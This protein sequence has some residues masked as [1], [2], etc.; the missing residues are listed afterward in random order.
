MILT[1]FNFFYLLDSDFKISNLARK[2]KILLILNFFTIFFIAKAA[3]TIGISLLI[4]LLF[5]SKNFNFFQKQNVVMLLSFSF[6]FIFIINFFEVDESTNRGL[7]YLVIIDNLE[8]LNNLFVNDWS[9]N[10]RVE[11]IVSPLIA[12]YLNNGFPGGFN[13]FID[14][15][16]EI[17]RV[18]YNL[19]NLEFV[20]KIDINNINE[21]KISSFIGDFIFQ[22]GIFGFII[23]LLLILKII[24][25]N[26][27]L[28]SLIILFIFF[29]VTIN[30]QMTYS[31]LPLLLYLAMYKKKFI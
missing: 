17:G 30:P 20:S 15:R 2:E 18:F 7:R 11:N 31:F 4:M 13:G 24:K 14:N 27:F 8:E 16:E 10:S 12:S 5:F 3:T 23:I 1:L 22:E 21:M 29:I 19:S 26:S 25:N 6:I 28:D 9:F